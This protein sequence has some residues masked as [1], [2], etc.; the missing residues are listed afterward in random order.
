LQKSKAAYLNDPNLKLYDAEDVIFEFD[1]IVEVQKSPR[2]TI[3]E[4]FADHPTD[5]IE[6]EELDW[7][8]PVGDEI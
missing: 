6:D 5:F 8:N 3:Q 2:K 4:L 1:K 7:G